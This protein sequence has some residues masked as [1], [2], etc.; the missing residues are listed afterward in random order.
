MFSL[1]VPAWG[2]VLEFIFFFFF[3]LFVKLCEELFYRLVIS[4]NVVILVNDVKR[5]EGIGKT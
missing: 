5:S 1:Q 3:F 2:G 4:A